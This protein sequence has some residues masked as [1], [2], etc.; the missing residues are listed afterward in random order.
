MSESQPWNNLGYV[1]KCWMASKASLNA[2]IEGYDLKDCAIDTMKISTFGEYLA[3]KK[4]NEDPTN[5]SGWDDSLKDEKSLGKRYVIPVTLPN[6]RELDVI[7]DQKGR[8]EA[9]IVVNLGEGEKEFDLTPRIKKAIQDNVPENMDKVIGEEAY[10]ANFLPDSI[11]EYAEKVRKDELIPKDKKHAAQIAGIQTAELQ[12]TDGRD[13]E[14]QN[15][16]KEIPAEA[17][18]EI[19][20]I[21]MDWI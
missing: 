15:A 2:S 7:V 13:S 4:R 16:E 11:D 21:C 17:R 8:D 20:K 10:K 3:N 19:A 6:G 1:E 18:D 14:R 9:R 5:P 12:K